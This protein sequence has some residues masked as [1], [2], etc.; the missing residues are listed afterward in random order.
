MVNKE[1]LKSV[2]SEELEISIVNGEDTIKIKSWLLVVKFEEATKVVLTHTNRLPDCH[3]TD[4]GAVDMYLKELRE[5]VKKEH[6]L[7]G[8]VTWYEFSPMGVAMSDGEREIDT[9]EI[10]R[11]SFD[12][13]GNPTHEDEYDITEL[14]DA[15]CLKEKT[16][17]DI[18]V[19][20]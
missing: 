14:A 17:L 15:L 4:I 5:A 2:I 16:L 13:N 7:S 20:D 8:S 6:V 18:V 1:K 12:D 9:E 10:F 3:V 19:L 11:V